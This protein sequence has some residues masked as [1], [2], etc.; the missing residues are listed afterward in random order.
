MMS[1]LNAKGGCFAAAALLFSVATPAEAAI[2]CWDETRAAAAEV[3]DLQL[4][5]MVGTLRCQAKG[6]DVS[7]AYNRFMLANRITVRDA[8]RVIM[9]QFLAGYGSEAHYYHDRFDTALANVYGGYETDASGCAETQALADEATGAGGDP[10]AL[11]EI[12]K[13]VGTAR[14]LPGGRCAISFASVGGK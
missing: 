14:A 3:R 5:L 7:D 4:R 8:N 11:I 12:A 6:I 9:D 13:R 1:G 2:G 10:A